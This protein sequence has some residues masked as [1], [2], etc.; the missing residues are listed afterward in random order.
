MKISFLGYDYSLL[1]S[2]PR[3]IVFAMLYGKTETTNAG[4]TSA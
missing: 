4:E 3:K 1:G 2:F